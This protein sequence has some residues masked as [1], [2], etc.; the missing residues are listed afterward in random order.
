MQGW[1]LADSAKLPGLGGDEARTHS[2]NFPEHP[3]VLESEA[4]RKVTNRPKERQ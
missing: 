2:K 3:E 1:G 4:E